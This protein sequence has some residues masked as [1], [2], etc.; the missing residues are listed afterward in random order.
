M[1][2]AVALASSHSV[3]VA[4][5]AGQLQAAPQKAP[6][7][8]PMLQDTMDE[9]WSCPQL[10][11]SLTAY[12][13]ISTATKCTRDRSSEPELTSNST[14]FKCIFQ[15]IYFWPAGTAEQLRQQQQFLPTQHMHAC[16]NNQHLAAGDSR[17][18]LAPVL[19]HKALAPG[20]FKWMLFGDDDTIFF[21]DSVLEFL[22]DF[23]PNLPY[24][25]SGGAL[26]HMAACSTAQGGEAAMYVTWCTMLLPMK[27]WR[28]HTAEVCQM[29]ALQVCGQLLSRPADTWTLR[30]LFCLTLHHGC[31]CCLHTKLQTCTQLGLLCYETCKSLLLV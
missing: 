29:P 21:V 10:P 8:T 4:P 17:A 30:R 31:C 19:A 27:Q 9:L 18:A 7:H 24:F 26:V 11:A 6:R 23:D 13:P 22:Q 1:A 28:L 14:R 15:C 2:L 5:L 20:S 25:I 16:T 12:S 3:A